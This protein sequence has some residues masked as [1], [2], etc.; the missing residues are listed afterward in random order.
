MKSKKE[1]EDKLYKITR[2]TPAINSVAQALR[3]V[4]E[5]KG[6]DDTIDIINEN[7][8]RSKGEPEQ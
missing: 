1:I 2:G 6:F 7:A 3:W 8:K 5:H 4:L